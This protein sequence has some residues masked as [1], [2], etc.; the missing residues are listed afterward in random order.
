VKFFH[1]GFYFLALS[2]P[3]LCF[4]KFFGIFGARFGPIVTS[5]FIRVP[6]YSTFLPNYST[7]LPIKCQIIQPFAKLFNLFLP[8]N[9]KLFNLCQIIQPIIGTLRKECVNILYS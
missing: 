8:Q 9:A 4:G 1:L 5:P 2:P 3:P 7:F 6:N